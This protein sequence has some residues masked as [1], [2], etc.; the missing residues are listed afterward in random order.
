MFF[1]FCEILQHVT[2]LY[3]L[4][5]FICT[6]QFKNNLADHKYSDNIDNAFTTH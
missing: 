2:K 5:F 3:S 4:Y 6:I 1:Y